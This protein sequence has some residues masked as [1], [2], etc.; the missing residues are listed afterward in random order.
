MR[1]G[2]VYT[3]LL[4][5]TLPLGLA[6]QSAQQLRK[7]AD[8]ITAD[9]IRQRIG[10]IAHDS[11]GG[12]NTP[13]PGLEKTAA[14]LAGLYQKWGMKPAGENGTWY[15]RY[16]MVKKGINQATA[17]LEVTENG[18][19]S[20]YPM[21][22]FAYAFGGG[23]PAPISAPGILLGGA[24]T[25]ADLDGRDLTGQIVM[26]V[27]DAGKMIDGNRLV[28]AVARMQPAA[29]IVLRNDAPEA[30]D[31]GRA[32]QTSPRYQLEKAG[33]STLPTIL[34]LHDQLFAG[35]PMA[36]SRPHFA[37]IRSSTTPV[38]M[39]FPPEV[40]VK[41]TAVEEVF[42]RVM[43][44]NV[45]GMIEGSDPVLKQEYV[46]YSAHMDHVG[47]V[48]DGVGGCS[49]RGDDDRSDMICNGADDDA[50]GTTGIAAIGE[51]FAGLPTK[52]KRSIIILNVSG[53]E[54]GLL[55]SEW[56][57]DH[58]TVPLDK[59]VANFNLDMIG[60]NNPDS[61]VVIGQEHSNLGTTLA[62]VNA[63]H[64]ELRM[65]TSEDLWPEQ[66]FYERSDHFNFA[67]YGVPV[68]FFFN[69]IHDQYHRVADHVDLI[70]TDKLSRVARI[71]FYAGAEVA[72]TVERPKWDPASYE[73]FV[74]KK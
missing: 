18:V 33:S 6:A 41:I 5:L 34:A 19:V 45:V 4:A 2:L 68:L 52:P 53:E 73:K 69:G 32:A 49:H 8:G 20:R 47:T 38:I 17:E 57:S 28:Q 37:D 65:T 67:R 64:P 72:N 60:R 42:D 39:P 66:R 31:R 12:R 10:V 11:M 35:D 43:V 44:P 30:F 22:E 14:Y 21:G 15:Q 29:L 13:S 70:D 16:P 36:A 58:P 55:G 40:S 9:V 46:I 3:S 56:Y 74:V 23:S 48:G 54:K 51:A 24:I 7:A 62:A 61:I 50:S 63:R 71:A 1:F 59:I 25:P 26:V 27:M